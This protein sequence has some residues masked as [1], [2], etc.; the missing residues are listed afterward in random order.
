MYE[1]KLDWAAGVSPPLFTN[2]SRNAETPMPPVNAA[3][4]GR[5][6]SVILATEILASAAA[7]TFGGEKSN[8]PNP[9][10]YVPCP[11]P[12]NL[13]VPPSDMA[14]TTSSFSGDV[15]TPSSP[16]HPA[17]RRST[18]TRP[19]MGSRKMIFRQTTCRR[20]APADRS[21]LAVHRDHI[22]LPVHSNYIRLLIRILGV[23]GH[24]A[25]EL[26]AEDAVRDF[27]A[28]TGAAAGAAVGE[29]AGAA[30]CN[31][32]V[33]ATPPVA[34]SRRSKIANGSARQ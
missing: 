21:R 16:R 13:P 6:G 32:R 12:D 9:G 17:V 34:E 1:L 30:S 25:S 27:P 15:W 2:G 10:V 8:R 11:L 19:Q 33:F 24:Q 3:S 20:P 29:P 23:P 26:I 4:Q 5:D 22:C 31:A 28:T 14:T 18:R 7:V